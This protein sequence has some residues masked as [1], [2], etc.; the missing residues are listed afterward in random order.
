LQEALRLRHGAWGPEDWLW[1]GLTEQRLG[2]AEAAGAWFN[3]TNQWIERADSG[4]LN[5]PDGPRTLA[6][7]LSEL[8]LLQRQASAM[9][10]GR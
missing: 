6:I 9:P 1:L 7:R 4:K 2:N 8:R 5:V 10:R 3:K